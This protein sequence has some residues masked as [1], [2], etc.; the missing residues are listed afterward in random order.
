MHNNTE[1]A[2]VAYWPGFCPFLLNKPTSAF[3][4]LEGRIIAGLNIRKQSDA[5]QIVLRIHRILNGIVILMLDKFS[6]NGV[7]NKNC[8]AQF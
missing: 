7:K 3:L 2:T 6:I 4:P 1:L 5:R 8:V